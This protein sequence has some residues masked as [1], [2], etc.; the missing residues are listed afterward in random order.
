M[1]GLVCYL[2]LCSFLGEKNY[3]PLIIFQKEPSMIE[4][5]EGEKS[6]KK[7]TRVATAAED[8]RKNTQLVFLTFP[9]ELY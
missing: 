4:I 8:V 6:E 2:L 1:F 9:N 5:K 3:T 7:N